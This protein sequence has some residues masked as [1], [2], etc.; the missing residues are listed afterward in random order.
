MDNRSAIEPA[1][2]SKRHVRWPLIVIGLL[3]GHMTIMFVA[4]AL[5]THDRSSTVIPDYYQKSLNWDRAQ[6]DRRASEQMGWG[7]TVTPAPGV[8]PLGRREVLVGVTDAG[9]AAVADADVELSYY[10]LSHPGEAARA[11]VH[12]GA[13]GRARATLPMR[14]EGFWQIDVTVKSGERRFVTVLSQF[15]STAKQ[16]AL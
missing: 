9:G 5:A 7:V 1:S 15:V 2:R 12:T 3:L 11:N 6:A 10:H 4:V 16:G 14:Y 13:D 8:D